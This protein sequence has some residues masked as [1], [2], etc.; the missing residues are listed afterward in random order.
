MGWF[1]NIDKIKSSVKQQMKNKI[2]TVKAEAEIARIEKEIEELEAKNNETLDTSP[3][4]DTSNTNS[5]EKPS[6]TALYIAIAA[7]GVV[8]IYLYLNKKKKK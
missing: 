1:K 7:V 3:S 2:A 6:N 4:V 5:S 8:G